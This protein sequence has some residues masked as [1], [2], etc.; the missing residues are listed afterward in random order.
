MK[1]GFLGIL[2]F[3]VG[4]KEYVG[5]FRWKRKKGLSGDF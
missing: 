1:E 5:V 3:D 4:F 2:I